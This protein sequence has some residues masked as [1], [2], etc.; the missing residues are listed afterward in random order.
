MSF[1]TPLWLEMK[2]F[3]TF[4][5][6]GSNLLRWEFTWRNTPRIWWNFGTVL[7]FQAR[8]TQTRSVLPLSNQHVPQVKNQV[9]KQC[10]HNKHKNFPSGLHVM[11]LFFLTRLVDGCVFSVRAAW[12]V[13]RLA[14]LYVCKLHKVTAW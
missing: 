4:M 6:P 10:C 11:Y 12:G 14:R 9:R 8:F 13:L 7:P 3:T 2:H 1:W 5:N